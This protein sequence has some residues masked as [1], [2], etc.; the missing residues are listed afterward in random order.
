MAQLYVIDRESGIPR[1][2]KELKGFEKVMLE[3][4]EAKEVSILLSGEDFS[5][6]N[7][8]FGK[9]VCEPGEFDIIIAPSSAQVAQKVTVVLI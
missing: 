6:W 4:G 1:P 3:A 2:P 5:Y 7:P 9:W 8:V